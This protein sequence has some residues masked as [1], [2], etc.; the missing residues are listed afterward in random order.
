MPRKRLLF[1]DDDA[2][3][4]FFVK[5]NVPYADMAATAQEAIAKLKTCVY[6]V[7]SLDH[8]LGEKTMVQSGHGT[9]YEVAEFIAALP[10]KPLG[11][12]PRVVLHSFNPVGVKNMAHVLA[13]AG[14][15]IYT[16]PFDT[17][18]FWKI[19][20]KCRRISPNS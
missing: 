12:W 5:S 14:Y 19:I 2:H 1:L 4:R 3:R 6:D 8:D 15:I 11:G 10:R 18:V 13:G 9:G 16:A 20:K 17:P 7:V